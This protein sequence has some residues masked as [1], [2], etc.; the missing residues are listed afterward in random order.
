MSFS[1]WV[2]L[3][4]FFF[5]FRKFLINMCVFL[6]IIFEK[7]LVLLR[8]VC[9]VSFVVCLFLKY[10][11]LNMGYVIVLLFWLEEMKLCKGG[12]D[13]K[14]DL[15]LSRVF[16]M[17]LILLRMIIFWFLSFMENI[18]LY[19]LVSFVMFLWGVELKRNIFL[20]MGIFYGLGGFFVFDDGVIF[21]ENSKRIR[22]VRVIIKMECF[23]KVFRM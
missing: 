5:E 1:R 4:W 22:R 3:K 20:I 17:V 16:F 23:V 14:L 9:M 15:F 21:F 2:G 19:C 10:F 6:R 13:E 11:G 7:C 8:M 12:W 18:F